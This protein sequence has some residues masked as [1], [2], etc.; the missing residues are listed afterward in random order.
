MEY[1]RSN[2]WEQGL[3]E[4]LITGISRFEELRLKALAR[5]ARF[6]TRTKYFRETFKAL[7]AL[8]LTESWHCRCSDFYFSHHHWLFPYCSVCNTVS[9]EAGDRPIV[10]GLSQFLRDGLYARCLVRGNEIHVVGKAEI[11]MGGWIPPND[12]EHR[13]LRRCLEIAVRAAAWFDITIPTD[14]GRPDCFSPQ[15]QTALED[16]VNLINTCLRVKEPLVYGRFLQKQM[17]ELAQS[18]NSGQ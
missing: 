17:E 8:T 15:M 14:A 6:P 9:P 16:I 11:T 2:G 18:A 7:E 10:F 4:G 3:T 1:A 13:D 5:R 12:G